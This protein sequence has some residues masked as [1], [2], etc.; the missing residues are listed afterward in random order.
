MNKKLMASAAAACSLVFALGLTAC[1]SAP[2]S[3]SAS[4]SAASSN[5]ASSMSMQTPSDTAAEYDEVG[6]KVSGG[7]SIEFTNKLGKNIAQVQVKKT[8][9]AEY[10]AGLLAEGKTI[11]NGQTVVL[12]CPDIPS[13][14][15]GDVPLNPM[16]DILLTMAD[17]S[18]VELHQVTV[19]AMSKASVRAEGDVAYLEFTASDGTSSQSTLESEKAIAQQKAEAAAQQAQAEQQQQ[20]AEAQTQG[21]G[22]G[23]AEPVYYEQP[24][25]EE[26]VPPAVDDSSVGGGSEEACIDDVVLR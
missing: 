20:Q 3:S 24:T 7:A 11:E 4:A 26:Y 16:A 2:A 14:T 1:G 6:T 25:Y 23:A 17:G 13:E 12:N 9:D 10:P 5:A 15:Q 19:Y 8:G 22:A 21:D 18:Q